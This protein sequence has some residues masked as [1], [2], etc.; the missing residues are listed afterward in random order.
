MLVAELV[1][2]VLVVIVAVHVKMGRY[3]THVYE[4]LYLLL[5]AATYPLLRSA[6]IATNVLP[7]AVPAN[8]VLATASPVVT[9][10]R[11]ALLSMMC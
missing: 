7:S 1:P 6:A 3:S 11:M 8:D 10:I 9:L 5:A 4:T 2:C